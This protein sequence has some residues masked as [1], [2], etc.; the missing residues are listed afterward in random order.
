MSS[1]GRRSCE[2]IMKENTLVTHSCV[3]S[4]ARFRDFKFWTWGLEIKFMENYFFLEN[5]VTSEGAVSHNVLY[6]QPFSI[7]LYL[8]RFF[9]YNYFEWFRDLGVRC[10]GPEIKHLK[11]HLHVTRFFFIRSLLSRKFDDQL[12]SN[13]HRFVILCIVMLRYTS[14]ENWSSTMSNSGQCL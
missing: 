13:F 7:T 6:H 10:R 5:Y 12:N 11:A 1:I 4:D 8:V 2:I 9:A 3:L 14:W